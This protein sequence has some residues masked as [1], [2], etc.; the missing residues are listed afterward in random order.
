M[1]LMH[2]FGILGT[3]LLVPNILTISLL[4]S[5]IIASYGLCLEEE[6]GLL[7]MYG[8]EY[9]HYKKKVGLLFPKLKM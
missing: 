9:E 2:V 3:S 4:V 5:T 8:E 1:Y 7:K 6:K